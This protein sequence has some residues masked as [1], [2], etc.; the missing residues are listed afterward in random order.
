MPVGLLPEWEDAPETVSGAGQDRTGRQRDDP[1]LRVSVPQY[2]SYYLPVPQNWITIS[3][4]R[5]ISKHP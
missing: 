1:S 4:E 3:H 5:Q 2:I